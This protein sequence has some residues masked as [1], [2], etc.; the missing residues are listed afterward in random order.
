MGRIVVIS[1]SP[2]GAHV[3]ETSIRGC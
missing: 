1:C 3:E 2:D